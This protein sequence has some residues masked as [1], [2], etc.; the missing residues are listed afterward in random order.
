[1]NVAGGSFLGVT[2][3]EFVAAFLVLLLPAILYGLSFPWI[4]ALYAPD[5]QSAGV[6]IGRLYAV[7]TAG[8]VTGAIVA[9]VALIPLAGGYVALAVAIA[10]SAVAGMV[11]QKRALA[12]GAVAA[13]GLVCAPLFRLT[14]LDEEGVMHSFHHATLYESGLYLS[15]IANM[16]DYLFLADGLNATVGVR[17]GEGDLA[18]RIN[19]KVDGS[20]H[21]MQTQV[22]LAALP[23]AS[24]PAPKK[25]LIIGFGTGVTTH[26][27]AIWPGIER[28][29]TVEIEPAVLEAAPYLKSLNAGVLQDPRS[30]VIV[31]DARRYLARAGDQYDVIISEP[32]NPWLAG[33]G[34]L[35]TAE[36]YRDVQT[37]L[38]PGGI[39]TQWLQGYQLL[40]ED[41]AMVTRTMAGS[42]PTMAL[43][44]GE[45][46]D[47]LV[48]GTEHPVWPTTPQFLAALDHAP[49]IRTI[50][51]DELHIEAPSGIWAYLQ[52]GNDD[53][54]RFAAGAEAGAGAGAGE[55][56]TDDKPLLEYRAPLR[57]LRAPDSAITAA[58][59]A[60]RRTPLPVTLDSGQQLDL[61]RTLM[62]LGA[63]DAS[64]SVARPLLAVL[65]DRAEI[66]QY[67][68]DVN[69]Q[70]GNLPVA[71]S[72]YQKALDRAKTPAER[73]A[74]LNGLGHAT[75]AALTP[76]AAHDSEGPFRRALDMR[77]EFRERGD[78][79]IGLATALSLQGKWAEAL[80]LQRDGLAGSGERDKA[81]LWARLGDLYL[82]TGDG[83]RA[84]EAFD[85]ALEINPYCYAAHRTL[86]EFF[87]ADR[88]YAESAREFQFLLRY[89]PLREPGMYDHAAEAL[90]GA[91]ELADAARATARKQRLFKPQQAQP[92]PQIAPTPVPTPA[93]TKP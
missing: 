24:H 34:N 3:L 19:G 43:W 84:K 67:A 62:H 88:K 52:L 12:F 35:Y 85:K 81:F 13:V 20:N 10:V 42:F 32:S 56:N 27:A 53:L 2:I 49:A 36:F 44:N 40:P 89:H 78:A 80:P 64:R 55:R 82:R 77:E 54:H 69:R 71:R 58:V 68:G 37:R 39:F 90:R 16:G 31:A 17:R 28:V 21:D 11:L 75:L 48:L 57:L 25:V 93:P 60:A 86:A 87:L 70:S 74:A 51:R 59:N 9:G 23:L 79:M 76:A 4:A 45:G 50:F 72:S 18:L 33:V 22:M 66:W 5:E 8:S 61:A 38:A 41:L 47:F 92:A 63:L 73:G 29:D 65:G 30:K 46:P 26:V 91:G 7:N 83:G 1:M 14:P 6:R 15:E